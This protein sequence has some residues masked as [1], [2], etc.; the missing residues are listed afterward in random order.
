MEEELSPSAIIPTPAPKKKRWFKRWW[1]ITIIVFILLTIV[2]AAV[3]I[4]QIYALIN[5]PENEVSDLKVYDVSADNDPYLGSPDAKVKI[6]AFE[7]FECPFCGEAFSIIRELTSTYG[8]QIQFVFRDFPI[9]ENHPNAPKAHEAAECANAQGKFWQMHD[10]LYQNQENLSVAD[11]K[12]FAIGIGLDAKSFDTCL[13]SGR[14]A[15]EIEKDRTD[16]IA[17]D[18]RGTPTWFL[19]GYRI[20]GVVPLEDFKALI[21]LLLAN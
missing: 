4:F 9:V 12:Q 3:L 19:N 11:L 10:K 17:V 5:N 18:V 16:G 1:G 6:I 14:F 7:D 2:F 15:A 21:D 8:D 13:D 20:E